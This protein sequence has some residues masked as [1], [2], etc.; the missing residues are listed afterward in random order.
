MDETAKRRNG[1]RSSPVG[2]LFRPFIAFQ[3]RRQAA[4]LQSALRAPNPR[5]L[6]DS[7]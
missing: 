7:F 4:A 2:F 6:A 1:E 5:R 3:K